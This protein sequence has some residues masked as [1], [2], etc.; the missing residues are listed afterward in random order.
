MAAFAGRQ[1]ILELD[2][3]PVAALTSKTFE[4]NKELIDISSDDSGAW[5]KK[6][7]TVVGSNSVTISASGVMQDE[8]LLTEAFASSPSA[9][10]DF[11]FPTDLAGATTGPTV[12]G[13]FLMTS[14][15][16]TG[17]T[18]DKFTFDVSF[19]SSGTVTFTAGV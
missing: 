7:E 1:V 15:S 18:A 2:S 17:E 14:F 10:L 3:T 11:I 9:A 4:I 16:S 5:V 19:E 8:A 12:S 13:T 6:L